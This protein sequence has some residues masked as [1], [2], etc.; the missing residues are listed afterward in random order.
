MGRKQAELKPRLVSGSVSDPE[1]A[2]RKRACRANAC[3]PSS[4]E[5][6][7]RAL[8]WFKNMSTVNKD[9]NL[10]VSGVQRE[11]L[12]EKKREIRTQWQLSLGNKVIEKYIQ[13][14]RTYDATRE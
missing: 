4:S 5:L 9:M 7:A 12:K 3:E 14:V 8:H 6:E 2:F 13:A 10:S 1:Q 11:K